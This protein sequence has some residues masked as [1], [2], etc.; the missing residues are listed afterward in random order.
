MIHG[1]GRFR[2][3]L[4]AL[5]GAGAIFLAAA[6]DS[7]TRPSLPFTTTDVRVGTGIEAQTGKILT[8]HYTGWVYREDATEHKGRQFDSSVNRGPF[9]FLLG[10]NAVIEGWDRGLVGMKVG[11]LRR[12]LIPPDLAYGATRTN[13]VIPPSATLI[14]EVELLD[15]Q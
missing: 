13:D 11:G 10:S 4:T 5:C 2:P 15:V 7:P 6:C 8:V 3:I 14:F 12:L 1:R 9:T